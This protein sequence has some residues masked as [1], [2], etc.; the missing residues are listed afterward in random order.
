MID[1]AQSK[2]SLDMT[3]D[4]QTIYSRMFHHNSPGP[5][6]TLLMRQVSDAVEPFPKLKTE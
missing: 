6:L 4:G 2:W 5:V 3:R 1:T